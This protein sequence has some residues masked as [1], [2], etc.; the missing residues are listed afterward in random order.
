MPPAD[1][2]SRRRQW[3]LSVETAIRSHTDADRGYGH[4][5]PSAGFC[6]I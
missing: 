2:T 6:R 4:R 3:T 5:R 1:A